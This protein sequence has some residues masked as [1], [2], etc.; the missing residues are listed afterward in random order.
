MSCGSPAAARYQIC[1]WKSKHRSIELWEH[2]DKNPPTKVTAAA[3]SLFTFAVGKVNLNKHLQIAP[4]GEVGNKE[5]DVISQGG[6][7]PRVG[8]LRSQQQR[9][10]PTIVPVLGS[11]FRV[12]GSEFRIQSSGFRV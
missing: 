2:L 6:D 11:G 12:Q 9:L 5:S 10:R 4:A 3:D 1:S 7:A 8:A